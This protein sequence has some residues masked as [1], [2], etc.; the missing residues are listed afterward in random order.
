MCFCVPRI[1]WLLLVFA[2]DLFE[3]IQEDVGVLTLEDQRRS[4]SDGPLTV[5]ADVDT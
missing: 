1:H 4:Q 5:A 3:L 2:Q